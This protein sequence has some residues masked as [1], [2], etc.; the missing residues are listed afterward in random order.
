MVHSC[1]MIFTIL[2]Q[3]STSFSPRNTLDHRDLVKFFARFFKI[4]FGLIERR[5]SVSPPALLSNDFYRTPCQMPLIYVPIQVPGNRN[6]CPSIY[7]IYF[8]NSSL[9]HKLLQSI[10]YK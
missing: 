10:Y 4:H 5:A 3:K 8:G 2:L 7:F 1:T 9:K 6:V